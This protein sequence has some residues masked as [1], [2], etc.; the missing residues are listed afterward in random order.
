MP[1]NKRFDYPGAWHHV[2]NRGIARRP[3]YEHGEDM[4]VFLAL[5]AL[6]A[7]ARRIEVHAFSLMG[8]HFHFLV[9]SLEAAL[10]EAM[11]QIQNRYSRWFNRKN[12]RDG[13]LFRGRYLAKLT[14]DPDYR[15]VVLRYIDSRAAGRK[16]TPSSDGAGR[17]APSPRVL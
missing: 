7:R 10:A 6:Q 12:K 11:R 14:D 3:L 2:M 1:R 4:R 8:T 16:R 9:R 15:R 17:T 13:P 5:T